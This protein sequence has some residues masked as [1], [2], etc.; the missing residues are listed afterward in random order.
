MDRQP[1]KASAPRRVV[2]VGGGFAGLAVTKRLAGDRRV[3]VA[4]VDQR[5]H[6]LFQPLLYQVATAGLS[7][8]EIA[9]PIRSQFRGDPNVTVYL[10]EVAR[11]DL[12]E[13]VVL[14]PELPRLRYDAL[15]LACGSQHSYF[16]HPEWESH[17]PGLKT[18]EQATEIRRRILTAFERAET[19]EDPAAIQGLL[20]F[21][22]V[23]GGPTGVELAGAI[24][25]VA[26]TVLVDDFRHIDPSLSHVLLL[27]AGPRI[28][29]SFDESL[30]AHAARDLAHLGVRVRTGAR[31]TG[32]DEGGV[33]LGPERISSRTVLW[34]AG[35]EAARLG[36][37][38]GV[39]LDRA[40]RV[41]V[42]PDL[43]VPGHPDVFVAGDMA[44]VTGPDGRSIP[45]VAPAALQM[46]KT[47]AWNILA[48]A[49]GAPRAPF[50][51]VDKGSMATIGKHRAIAQVGQLK[52]RGYVA[53]LAWLFVHVFYLVGFR[54]RVRVFGEWMWS[55]AFSRRGARLITQK[56]WRTA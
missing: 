27:E 25:D 18:L 51:Y 54:R 19:L 44:L 42:L 5:N 43:S 20:T 23:G 2:V 14:G 38:L 9:V 48:D 12:A 32:L 28:L 21:V 15:V 34:A 37:T 6:H 13:R 22:V 29:P 56:E 40:G 17:A 30:S 49:E 39:E 55:Y 47:V 1:R 46:G 11:V 16:G 50:R 31:V 35:V 45:G 36:R 3:Q 33:Q 7:P 10:G 8:S 53:W 52:L 4:L 26:R 24:A 41:R